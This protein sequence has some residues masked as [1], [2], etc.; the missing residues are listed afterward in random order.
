[1]FLGS[2]LYPAKITY[3]NTRFKL[4]QSQ[5]ILRVA[6][7]CYNLTKAEGKR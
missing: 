2:L 7:A 5:T 3:M 6:T 1:M 4:L